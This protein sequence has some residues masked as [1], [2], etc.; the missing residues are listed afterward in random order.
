MVLDDTDEGSS[1]VKKP[2][3]EPKNGEE[4]VKKVKKEPKEKVVVSSARVFLFFVGSRRAV[5][6]GR[7]SSS[8]GEGRNAD[9]N[10][11]SISASVGSC[12][13]S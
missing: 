10:S 4:T 9:L 12:Q 13:R 6:S 3:K 7:L 8:F 1:P 5:F 11:L 2:K